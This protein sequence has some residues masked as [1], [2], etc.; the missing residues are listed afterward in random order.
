MIEED[1]KSYIKSYYLDRKMAYTKLDKHDRAIGVLLN[2]NK[3]LKELCDK[4]EEEH[5]TTFDTWLKGQKV[6][7]ELE[8]KLNQE[9][10]EGRSEEN[11]W[12]MG[13]YDYAKE[14]LFFIQE[15]KEKYK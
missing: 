13:V 10:D 14:I 7:T 8:E 12:L 11:I 3:Q 15:L 9:I 2:E 1:L 5:K 6:L 4:Y